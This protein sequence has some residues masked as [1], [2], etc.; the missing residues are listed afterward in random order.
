MVCEPNRFE[1]AVVLVFDVFCRRALN[2]PGVVRFSAVA[3]VG[4]SK[5]YTSPFIDLQQKLDPATCEFVC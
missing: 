3:H 5:V 4:A 2:A 1:I